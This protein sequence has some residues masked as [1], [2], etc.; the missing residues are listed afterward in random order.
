MRY[1]GQQGYT[2]RYIY[3]DGIWDRPN[4]RA[5]FVQRIKSRALAMFGLT[6]YA[7]SDFLLLV[8]RPP[9]CQAAEAVDWRPV[10][11][12]DFRTTAEAKTTA[13]SK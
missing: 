7:P 12:R 3:Y 2:R 9:H 1:A 11:N 4:P 13:A 8:E 10:W 5:I 6:A